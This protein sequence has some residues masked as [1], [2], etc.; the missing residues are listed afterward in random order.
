MSFDKIAIANTVLLV[1]TPNAVHVDP[2]HFAI[3]LA[4]NVP[5]CPKL[6]PA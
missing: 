5:I 4:L 6:P 3:L 2:F 1:P